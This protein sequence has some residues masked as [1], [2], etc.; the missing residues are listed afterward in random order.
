[1]QK[2]KLYS[3]FSKISSK[4]IVLLNILFP[5]MLLIF[6]WFTVSYI[7]ASVKS[8]TY[9]EYA[10]KPIADHIFLSLALVFGGAAIFDC[11]IKNGDLKK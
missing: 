7:N 8:P 1:M 5:I 9:A 2:N 11:S 10:F 3:A 4:T 6:V